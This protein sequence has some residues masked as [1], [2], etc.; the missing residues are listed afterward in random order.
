MN[1]IIWEFVCRKMPSTFFS[2]SLIK[3][4]QKLRTRKI[5][6]SHWK[7]IG[8][9]FLYCR[10]LWYGKNYISREVK[11]LSQSWLSSW[12]LF[13]TSVPYILLLSVIQLITIKYFMLHTLNDGFWTI[14]SEERISPLNVL[15]I[16]RLSMNL[17][18][19]WSHIYVH[20]DSGFLRIPSIHHFI[21]AFKTDTR[22]HDQ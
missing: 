10:S 11:Y 8:N 16:S 13:S 17:V 1:E 15:P 2:F 12:W 22:S 7:S 9:I 20:V 4:Q 21:I 3:K 18:K 5:N 14:L 19:T 6:Q